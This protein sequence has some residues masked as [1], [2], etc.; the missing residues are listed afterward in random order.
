M[1]RTIIRPDEAGVLRDGEGLA[2]NDTGQW[3]DEN[4]QLIEEVVQDDGVARDHAVGAGG[5]DRHQQAAVDRYVVQGA[6]GAVV[7]RG[8]TLGDYNRP[9]QFYA[10]LCAIRPLPFQRNDFEL[11]P[12]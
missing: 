3:I 7:Q 8:M 9:E 5:V 2:Y 10:N 6:A 1:L 12:A 11:K 4:G